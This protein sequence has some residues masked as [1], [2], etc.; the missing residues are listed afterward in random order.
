M[1]FDFRHYTELDYLLLTQYFTNNILVIG[2]DA[3]HK[4]KCQHSAFKRDKGDKALQESL[5]N[6]LL[7]QKYF[8]VASPVPNDYYVYKETSVDFIKF[9]LNNKLCLSKFHPQGREIT[10]ALRNQLDN[11]TCSIFLFIS[12]ETGYKWYMLGWERVLTMDAPRR[13]G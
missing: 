6:V 1:S 7:N 12:K 4:T 13:Y 10:H 8:L 11:E 2:D 9:S 5:I 3:L